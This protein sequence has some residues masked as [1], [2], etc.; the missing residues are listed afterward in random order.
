MDGPAIEAFVAK[1]FPQAVGFCSIVSV[2]DELVAELQAGD[3]YL[4]PGGTVSG[5]TLMTLAD[6]AMYFL[7]LS[8]IGPVELAVTTNLNMNFLQRPP[9]GP[10]RA[11]AKMLK[12][13]RRL[14]VGEVSIFAGDK[15]G[16]VAHATLTYS[17]PPGDR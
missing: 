9:P 15:E 8:R 3:S 11:H 13:G 14:A 10:V 1:V 2:G 17:I 5:P 6:T 7:V 4:R 12:L 16:P